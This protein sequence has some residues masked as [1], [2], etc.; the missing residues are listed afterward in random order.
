MVGCLIFAGF[1]RVEIFKSSI[2][3]LRSVVES[4]PAPIEIHKR[5][6]TRV[7]AS[8]IGDLG[9]PASPIRSQLSLRALEAVVDILA[10]I[11]QGDFTFVGKIHVE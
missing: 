8:S 5:C 10:G 3:T 2:Y 6:G 4:T 11:R 1:A 7:T 9:S